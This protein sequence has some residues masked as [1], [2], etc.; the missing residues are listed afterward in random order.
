MALRWLAVGG[1]LLAA[2]GLLTQTAM[3]HHWTL[4][5][6]AL[7]V[8]VFLLP[9]AGLACIAVSLWRLQAHRQRA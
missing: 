6:S 3:E 8:A 1:V 5:H 4:H 9:V 7:G 2:Q